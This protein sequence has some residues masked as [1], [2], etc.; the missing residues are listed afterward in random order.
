MFFI[1]IVPKPIRKVQILAFF[2]WN[3]TKKFIMPSCRERHKGIIGKRHDHRLVEGCKLNDIVKV[4]E[5]TKKK[6]EDQIFCL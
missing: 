6:F 2:T 1:G 4:R 3:V 5:Y